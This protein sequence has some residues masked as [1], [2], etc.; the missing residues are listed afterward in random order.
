MY[1]L[2]K[3]TKMHYNTTYK[4]YQ[5]PS[6]IYNR[7]LYREIINKQRQFFYE[8]L[9]GYQEKQRLPEGRKYTIF[10]LDSIYKN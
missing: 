2:N 8:L 9:K 10:N 1:I 6:S 3:Y 4:K 7:D 5:K